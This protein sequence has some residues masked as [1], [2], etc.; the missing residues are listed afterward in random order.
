MPTA[1]SDKAISRLHSPNLEPALEIESRSD[2]GQPLMAVTTLARTESV[3]GESR[4]KASGALEPTIKPAVPRRRHSGMGLRKRLY[5]VDSDQRGDLE[6]H[7]DDGY[8]GDHED[9]VF[10]MDEANDKSLRKILSLDPTRTVSIAHDGRDKSP[11]SLLVHQTSYPTPPPEPDFYDTQEF[12]Q[13]PVNPEQAQLRPDSRVQH[14][15][16]LEDLTAGMSRPCVLDL[17]MGTRQYG[18]DADEKKQR[19]QR[20][21]CHMTTS[22]QLGVRVCG[23][24]VWNV[25]TR[26]YVFEDKYFGRDLRAG[27]DF[28]AALRRFFFDGIG[29]REARRHIPRVLEEIERLEGIIKN[30]P[31]YRFYASSLLML[32]D[33]GDEDGP[34]ASQSKNRRASLDRGVSGDG[35]EDARAGTQRE[36]TIMLKIVDFANCVTAEDTRAVNAKCPP[37]ERWGIDRGYL[38]GLRSL[39]LYFQ[40][41]FKLVQDQRFVTRGEGVG[42][43]AEE[44]NV[45]HGTTKEG[46]SEALMENT[47]DVS[48]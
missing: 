41:I 44:G 19:S 1:L 45:S 35:A 33:R 2:S 37:R 48:E 31:G 17:K 5:D 10:P 32:Y 24:Q 9:E 13:T 4:S 36:S 20:R 28:E 23:M 29:Y 27:G 30:L 34:T 38:R 26:G 39:R 40:Q 3:G 14:F 22:K 25:K 18:I 7:E 15:I 11:E 8:G 46:W 43:A 16:L 12:P 6:Y 47:G 21:K 42:G